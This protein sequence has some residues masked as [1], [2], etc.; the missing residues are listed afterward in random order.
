[1]YLNF[2]P[3]LY[4]LLLQMIVFPRAA[5]ENFVTKLAGEVYNNNNSR[6]IVAAMITSFLAVNNQKI[7]DL[8]NQGA[9]RFPDGYFVLND[10][11][12]S[13]LFY[14]LR[15]NL[16]SRD[17]TTSQMST[18]GT[19]GA[20]SSSRPEAFGNTGQAVNLSIQRHVESLQA[21]LQENPYTREVFE[22][23]HNFRWAEPPAG[24]RL[25][26]GDGDSGGQV[27]AAQVQG[28]RDVAE[29]VAVLGARF[30]REMGAVRTELLNRIVALENDNNTQNEMID[31]LNN[32][33]V[34]ANDNHILAMRE[35]ATANTRY[36]NLAAV[37]RALLARI[38]ELAQAANMDPV[39]VR[40]DE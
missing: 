24:Q 16:Q 6:S 11:K 20:G 34:T 38:N 32:L 27:A 1:M 4:F 39:N 10:A 3:R 36:N 12:V 18:I 5:F 7:G 14:D 13:K 15:F 23:S 22:S 30:D 19:L 2:Q 17:G 40:I 25:L 31:D 21:V 35:L 33:M 29:E 26:G 8:I 28:R 37:A 9:T